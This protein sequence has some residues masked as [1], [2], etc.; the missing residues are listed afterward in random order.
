MRLLLRETD[1]VSVGAANTAPGESLPRETAP[2]RHLHLLPISCLIM[3]LTAPTAPVEATGAALSNGLSNGC[4]ST[5]RGLP[6]CG[7]YVGAAY[8]HNADVSSWERSMRKTLGVHRTYYSAA[9]VPR[10]VATARADVAHHRVPWMSFKTPYAWADMARGKGDAW[11]RNLAT[12]LKRVR[13]P[14]WIAI[15]H[16]P[17]GDG[18]IAEWRAMQARLAPMMR[19]AAPNL[20]YTI[21]LTG[22]HEFRSGDRRYAMRAIWPRTK[23]DVAGFD[24]FED[25]GVGGDTTWKDFDN[26]YFIPIRA[27]SR[28]TGVRWALG[29]SGYSDE[30]AAK[31]P[32]WLSRTYR[33]MRAYGGI[34]FTYFNS[35][36]KSVT[37]W[38]LH[39][40]P[41]KAAFT[42]INRSAPIL[43]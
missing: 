12:R 27:W 8:K 19:A 22:Y 4:R 5:P 3:V 30:A 11:A 28:S 32:Q 18:V 41:K 35:K 20:A 40:A 34:A 13:G 10:A 29:E 21:I 39:T 6:Y 33:H 1:K 23:I 16:E 14:V 15:H 26:D 36:S 17:E 38:S 9:E 24:I 2:H 42:E 43:K 31:D 37:N 7:A 25:Y